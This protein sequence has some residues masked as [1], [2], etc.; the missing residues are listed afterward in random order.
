M[1]LHPDAA[2]QQSIWHAEE[3]GSHMQLAKGYKV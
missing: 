1:L 3:S 2:A